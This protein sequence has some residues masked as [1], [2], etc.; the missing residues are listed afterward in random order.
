MGVVFGGAWP[1]VKSSSEWTNYKCISGKSG[2]R[3]KFATGIPWEKAINWEKDI[4]TSE[5]Q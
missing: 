1:R 2:Q 3:C 4:N 5:A